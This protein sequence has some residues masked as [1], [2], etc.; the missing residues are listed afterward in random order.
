MNESTD[1]NTYADTD[2]TRTRTRTRIL[3]RTKARSCG[4]DW[5]LHRL[6]FACICLLVVGAFPA[7]CFSYLISFQQPRR[8]SRTPGSNLGPCENIPFVAAR[9]GHASI[10][11]FYAFLYFFVALFS[12]RR[13]RAL[14]ILVHFLVGVG[15]VV[16]NCCWQRN[17][18][19]I[20]VVFVPRPSAGTGFAKWMMAQ[21]LNN[22]RKWGFAVVARHKPKQDE[23]DE[24]FHTDFHCKW[25]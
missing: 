4:T 23:M 25:S 9:P 17:F 10:R 14:V 12:F 3:T 21:W 2:R 24:S 15:G 7:A 16:F 8:T 5:L 13:C 18:Q 19:Q 20:R 22:R 1:T 11:S 6:P